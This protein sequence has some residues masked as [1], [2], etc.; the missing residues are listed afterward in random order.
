MY[1]ADFLI[2][3][4]PELPLTDRMHL[5]DE[6][7]YMNGV[8]SAHFSPGHPHMM[9]IAYDPDTVSSSVVLARVCGHGIEASKIGL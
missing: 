5:E 6:I 4:H 2:N 9:T 3:V 1:M 8:V 7:G